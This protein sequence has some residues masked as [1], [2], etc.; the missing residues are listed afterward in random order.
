ML[1]DKLLV[2][3]FIDIIKQIEYTNFGIGRKCRN[4]RG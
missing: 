3:I 2:N 1:K 4:F